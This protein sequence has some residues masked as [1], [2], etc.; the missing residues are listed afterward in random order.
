[1]KGSSA[2]SPRISGAALLIVFLMI[3]SFA[4]LWLVAWWIGSVWGAVMAAGTIIGLMISIAWTVRHDAPG[5]SIGVLVASV[6]VAILL[7]RRSP[8]AGLFSVL[9]ALGVFGVWCLAYGVW[10]RRPHQSNTRWP[11][12]T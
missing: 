6:A 5:V 12:S 3:M 8:S 1:M 11:R 10:F 7:S 9:V 4:D 2:L